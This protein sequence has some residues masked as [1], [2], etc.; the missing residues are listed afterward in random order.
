MLELSANAIVNLSTTDRDAMSDPLAGMLVFNTT[1]STLQFYSGGG[2]VDIVSGDSVEGGLPFKG[3]TK[4]ASGEG[5]YVLDAVDTNPFTLPA[6]T[7]SGDRYVCAVVRTVSASDSYDY[8]LGDSS[9][10]DGTPVNVGTNVVNQILYPDI[11]IEA[12]TLL[13]LKINSDYTYTSG[14]RPTITLESTGGSEVGT[15]DLMENDTVNMT[16]SVS[17]DHGTYRLKISTYDDA[18]V[19]KTNNDQNF[20]AGNDE[21]S[22]LF[23]LRV[24]ATD[25]KYVSIGSSGSST[26]N[27]NSGLTE[28]TDGLVYIVDAFSDKYVYVRDNESELANHIDE[29]NPHNTGFGDLSDTPEYSAGSDGDILVLDGGSLS[30]SS[31]GNN[32]DVRNGLF[33]YINGIVPAS[34]KVLLQIADTLITFE[35][36]V[37]GSRA[38]CLSAPTSDCSFAVYKEESGSYGTQTILGMIN[39]TAGNNNGTFDFSNTATVGTGDLLYVQSPSELY[40]LQDLFINLNGKSSYPAY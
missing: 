33:G 4:T 16:H 28:F 3:V 27:G 10:D 22:A 31:A 6:A 36:G 26:F 1:T 9:A 35:S 40:G 20:N 18:V 13:S 38:Y 7:G 24:D 32:P 14:S 34:S 29:T 25:A 15:W 17:L 21:V 12:D 37:T 8:Y 5:I 30:W 2:W 11:L 23:Q 19:I 39:F